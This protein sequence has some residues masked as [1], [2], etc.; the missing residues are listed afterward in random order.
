M[1]QVRERFA[2]FGERGE[3]HEIQKSRTLVFLISIIKLLLQ[4]PK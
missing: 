1:R 2:S 4:T 3:E